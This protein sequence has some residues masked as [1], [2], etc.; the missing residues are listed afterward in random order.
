MLKDSSTQNEKPVIKC[1]SVFKIFGN[2]AKKILENSNGQ[3]SAKDFQEAGC[4]VGVNNATFE[5]HKGE[6]LVV[7]G[8]SGS[9]KSTLLRCISR[10]TD[11]T[12]GKIFLDGKDIAGLDESQLGDV[13]PRIQMIFQDP[14]AS[15]N[16]RMTVFDIIAEPLITH[17]ICSSKSE[18]EQEVSRL[19]EL[20]GLSPRFVKKYPHESSGGQRQRIAIARARATSLRSLSAMS[21]YQPLMYLYRRKSSTF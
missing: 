18:L 3:V 10:L 5:I 15:L 2:N 1:E 13:R 17:K 8:L 4:I 9:G 14:Y 7:M 20:V 19:M 12:A 6:M 16:P 21:Q 11:P